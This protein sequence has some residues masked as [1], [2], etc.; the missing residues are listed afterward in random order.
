MSYPNYTQETDYDCGP[1]CVRY[2]TIARGWGAL[3]GGPVDG[4]YVR[5]IRAAE[6]TP[7]FGTSHEGMLQLINGMGFSGRARIAPIEDVPLFAI[8]NYMSSEAVEGEKYPGDGHYG[9]VVG[10]SERNVYIWSPSYGK[11]ITYS[12]HEFN[13]VFYS[14]RYGSKWSVEVI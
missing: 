7:E 11:V 4:S 13:K 8:V 1:A 9:V 3:G 12:Y 2:L 14:N 6:T 10:K 5:M